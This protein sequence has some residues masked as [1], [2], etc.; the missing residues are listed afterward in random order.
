MNSKVYVD[1]MAEFTRDGHIFDI[2][3]IKDVR[4]A[5]SLRAGGII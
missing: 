5:A 4:R 1:V 2:D 3:R